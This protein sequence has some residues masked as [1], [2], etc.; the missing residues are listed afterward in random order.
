MQFDSSAVEALQALC[1]GFAFAGLLAS[2]FELVTERK[3][4]F[5]LLQ[6][7]GVLALASV[8]VVVFSAPFIIIRNTVRGR[9]VEGR[10]FHF[11]MIA[12]VI[13][14]VWSLLSGRLVLDLAQLLAAAA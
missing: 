13:A 1:L 8:P 6:M 3:A 12:T 5:N 7:G 11:V 2:G 10:P 9:R 14:S 4:S